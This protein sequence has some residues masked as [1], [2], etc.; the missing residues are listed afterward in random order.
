MR[1]HERS[2]NVANLYIHAIHMRNGIYKPILRQKLIHYSP[3]TLSLTLRAL[4]SQIF[5]DKRVYI[6]KF[7]LNKEKKEEKGKKGIVIIGCI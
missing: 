3:F 5:R 4:L 6:V 7:I 1:L 2:E